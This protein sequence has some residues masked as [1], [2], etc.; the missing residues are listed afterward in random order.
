[1]TTSTKS[2]LALGF[3][4]GS[5]SIIGSQDLY[6][7]R[8]WHGENQQAA[9]AQSPQNTRTSISVTS[10]QHGSR[11][12][13]EAIKEQQCFFT[14]QGTASNLGTGRYISLMLRVPGG[15]EWWHPGNSIRPRPNI[16][17]RPKVFL[18]KEYTRIKII[19][20]ASYFFSKIEL[21]TTDIHFSY[22][23]S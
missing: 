3:I 21:A 19:L 9:F 7:G 13:C 4:A 17:S 6:A 5:I 23:T 16:I 10:P 18:V 11:I 14:A 12:K 1:M 2:L 8:N 20:I 15:I 22:R